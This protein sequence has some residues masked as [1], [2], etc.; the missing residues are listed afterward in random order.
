M[1]E[2]KIREYSE[3]MGVEISKQDGK[4]GRLCIV[5]WNESGY[6]CTHV[7]LMDVLQWCKENNVKLPEEATA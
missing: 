7:D 1:T 3:G 4:K 5:A 2:T 6:N